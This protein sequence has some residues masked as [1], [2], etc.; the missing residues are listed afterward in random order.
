MKRYTHL[1]VSPT[2]NASDTDPTTV[3]CKPHEA[4]WWTLFG[5]TGSGEMEE[6]YNANWQSTIMEIL[7]TRTE[8]DFLPATLRIDGQ[9]DIPLGR[10]AVEPGTYV[11]LP[12]VQGDNGEFK[13]VYDGSEDR[14]AV[15]LYKDDHTYIIIGEH[16][17][18]VT[19]GFACANLIRY[20]AAAA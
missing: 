6:L 18:H 13:P 20:Q 15:V 10:R 7:Q 8:F 16:R 11:V 14:Y 2:R 4:N 12:G 5:A 17:N 1:Y 9:P 3:I 19:A